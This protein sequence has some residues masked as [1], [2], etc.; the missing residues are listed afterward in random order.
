MLVLLVIASVGATVSTAIDT[1]LLVSA[2]SALK[3]PPALL[4]LLLATLTVAAV[5]LALSGVNV[6]V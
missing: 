4:N 1:A 3:F 5:V 6:A 2:P